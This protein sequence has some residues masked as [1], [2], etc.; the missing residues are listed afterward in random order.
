MQTRVESHENDRNL[1][2][3]Q[4]LVLTLESI[5]SHWSARRRH[6][7]EV[8]EQG[9]KGGGRPREGETQCHSG[10][11]S[12]NTI[13][14]QTRSSAQSRYLDDRYEGIDRDG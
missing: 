5:H 13:T 12:R 4:S 10:V 14:A 1:A 2:P 7:S 9:S 11:L 6:W 3:L 8:A